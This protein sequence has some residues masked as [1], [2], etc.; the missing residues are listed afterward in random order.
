[1]PVNPNHFETVARQQMDYE[2][3]DFENWDNVC[4]NEEKEL[5]W[6][7]QEEIEEGYQRMEG[8]TLVYERPYALRFYDRN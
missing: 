4:Q 1:M 6:Y 3:L 7:W 2:L 5:A 8:W